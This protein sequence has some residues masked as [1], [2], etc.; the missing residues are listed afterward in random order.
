MKKIAACALAAALGWAVAGIG[1]AKLPAPTD[2]QKAKAA[3]AKAKA[4]EAAKK[5]TEA[6]TRCQD[7]TVDNFKRTRA[8]VKPQ[9]KR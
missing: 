1:Y 2:E 7:R 3:E 5:D 6:L 8:H 4:D 9:P